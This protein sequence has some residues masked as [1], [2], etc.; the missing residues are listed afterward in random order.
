MVLHRFVDLY[1]DEA[2]VIE[3]EQQQQWKGDITKINRR[4]VNLGL[5]ENEGPSVPDYSPK[6]FVAAVSNAEF[7]RTLRVL[8]ILKI[9]SVMMTSIESDQ[10]TVLHKIFARGSLTV[11]TT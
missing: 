7:N 1:L 9:G 5:A 11:K 6:L 10:Q 8:H 4:H 2:R 3:Q